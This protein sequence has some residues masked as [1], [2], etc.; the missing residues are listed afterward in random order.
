[1]PAPQRHSIQVPK[2]MTQISKNAKNQGRNKTFMIHS[3]EIATA[4]LPGGSR[5]PPKYLISKQNDTQVS[6]RIQ[7]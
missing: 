2:Q 1:M 7:K 5:N 4:L 3:G 6:Q